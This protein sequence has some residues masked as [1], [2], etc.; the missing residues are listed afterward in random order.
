MTTKGKYVFQSGYRDL[1]L[2]LIETGVRENTRIG[3]ALTSLGIS[4]ELPMGVVVYRPGFN[5]LL[6]FVEGLEVIGGTFN[7]SYYSLVAPRLRYEYKLED[8]SY[9]L[10]LAD[11]MPAVVEQL[12][13]TPT[14]RRA[15]AHIGN[16][17]EVGEKTKVCIDSYVFNILEGKLSIQLFARSWDMGTGFV[18]DTMV[19]SMVGMMVANIL[20]VEP[21]SVIGLAANAHVYLHDATIFSKPFEKGNSLLRLDLPF[22]PTSWEDVAAFARNTLKAGI[23]SIKSGGLENFNRQAFYK[24]AGF[25]F[26]EGK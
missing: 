15:I 22:Q 19:A 9:G 14:T 10:R 6:A 17:Q 18:Y 5:R 26:M 12:K 21:G 11:Q 3:E 8:S 4:V 24:S 13:S 7:P 16:P 25:T 1:I 20:G 2:D 23:D